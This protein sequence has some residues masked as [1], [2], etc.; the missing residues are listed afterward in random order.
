MI[1]SFKNKLNLKG[2]FTGVEDERERHKKAV[3]ITYA[4]L[5]QFILYK[6]LVDNGFAD[7]QADWESRVK[8]VRNALR[9]ESYGEILGRIKGISKKISENI[10]KRFSDEQEIINKHL[11]ELLAKPTNTINDVFG[12]A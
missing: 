7:F 3:E 10:Y 9:S 12:L 6:T 2:Y 1:E 8:E 5:I 11:E 4:Y